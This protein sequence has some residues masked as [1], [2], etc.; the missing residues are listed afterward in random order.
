MTLGLSQARPCATV[1]TARCFRMDTEESNHP[2]STPSCHPNDL[3]G[4]VKG[5]L[6]WGGSAAALIAGDRWASERS[7]LWFAAFLVAGLACLT[8]A[9]RCGRRHCYFTGPLFLLAAV[10]LAISGFHLVPLNERVF[11]DV[12]GITALLAFLPECLLGRY[13]KNS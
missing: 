11:L 4:S 1:T 2:P 6:I 12:V 13:K 3:V 9:A 8:N 10:Y 5:L 7:W